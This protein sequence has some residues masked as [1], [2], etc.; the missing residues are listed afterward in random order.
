MPR[1][2]F[3][4]AHRRDGHLYYVYADPGMCKCLYV[5]TAAQY[6]LALE[7]ELVL[8][9]DEALALPAHNDAV[10]WDLWA[11]WPGFSR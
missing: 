7:I 5:G 11:P 10:V 2:G 1:G 8:H 6:Q 3:H 9:R 4:S